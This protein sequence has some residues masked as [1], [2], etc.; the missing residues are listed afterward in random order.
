[1]VSRRWAARRILGLVWMAVP[2]GGLGS[3]AFS[4]VCGGCHESAVRK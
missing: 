1:M 2:W 4:E 3:P